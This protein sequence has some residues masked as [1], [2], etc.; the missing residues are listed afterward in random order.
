MSYRKISDVGTSV[1]KLGISKDG[2]KIEVLEVSTKEDKDAL[3]KDNSIVII[4]IY[5]D[6]CHPCQIASPLFADLSEKYKDL[7]AF[8][9]EQVE[10]RLSES[11]QVIP[12]F[13]VFNEGKLVKLITGPDIEAVE[14][15]IQKYLFKEDK[16][17]A[18]PVRRRRDTKKEEKVKEEVKKEEKKE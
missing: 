11:I 7:V 8:A 5:A 16:K 4:D 10:L 14:A 17:T 15:E 9:K 18:R 12:T 2:S 6:W 13:Q 3:I 1:K